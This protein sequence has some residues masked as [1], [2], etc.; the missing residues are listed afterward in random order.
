MCQ[1][2]GS[3]SGDSKQPCSVPDGPPKSNASGVSAAFAALH[4]CA[5]LQI[6]STTCV[7]AHGNRPKNVG[8]GIGIC[9]GRTDSKSEHMS[10][11]V[12]QDT[13]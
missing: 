12:P 8:I 4:V 1:G 6:A 13:L 2:A 3:K 5:S 7:S 10:T 11:P 9:H